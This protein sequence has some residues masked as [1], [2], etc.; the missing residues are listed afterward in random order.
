MTIESVMEDLYMR[1]IHRARAKNSHLH[2]ISD[3]FMQFSR[4]HK[5]SNIDVCRYLTVEFGKRNV[6]VVIGGSISMMTVIPPRFTKDIDLNI[7]GTYNLSEERL[8]SMICVIPDIDNNTF[9]Y[10]SDRVFFK[11]RNIPVDAFVHIGGDIEKRV[12]ERFYE[13]DGLKFAPIECLCFWKMMCGFES[14][15]FFKDRAD[16]VSMLSCAKNLDAEWVRYNLEKH[17]PERVIEWLSF[18]GRYYKLPSAT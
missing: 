1:K 10:N 17:K 14:D 13:E 16:I 3:L 4:N 11:C 7:R 6:E 18:V 5:G 8:Q 2:D 9:T 12:F 15:R